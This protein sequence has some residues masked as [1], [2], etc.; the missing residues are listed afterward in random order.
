MAGVNSKLRVD[1]DLFSGSGLA[2]NDYFNIDFYSIIN[3]EAGFDSGIKMNPTNQN[4]FLFNL[5]IL[6]PSFMINLSP[7]HS[8]ALTTRARGILNLNNIN[9]ELYEALEDG[10]DESKSI[11]AEMENL[12][13]TFHGWAEFGISYGR[14]LIEKPGKTLTGGISLK[15]LKGAGG[16]YINSSKLNGNYDSGSGTLMTSGD[17]IYVTSQ[18]FDSDAFSLSNTGSGVGIDFDMTYE[19]KGNK[20]T[21]IENPSNGYK[22]KVGLAIVDVGRISYKVYWP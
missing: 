17:F 7:K 11:Q 5:D 2:G 4:N 8:V 18:E 10:L 13:G 6:G 21:D 20:V 16:M 19:Y 14:L 1:I 3:G 22:L 12:N 9:G 15:Y